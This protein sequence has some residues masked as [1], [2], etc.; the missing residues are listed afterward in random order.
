MKK[1]QFSRVYKKRNKFRY[2]I[3]ILTTGKNS[4]IKDFSWCVVERYNG[5][6]VVKVEKRDCQ[7]AL[8][9]PID[10]VYDPAEGPDQNIEC[11]Y[12]SKI[13]FV[14]RPKYSKGAAGIDTLDA[15]ECYA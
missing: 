14:Y 7:E 1:N 11:Y 3:R 8:F 12:T 6:Q 9:E 10:I 5:Y 13:Y 15:F 4:V 2:L